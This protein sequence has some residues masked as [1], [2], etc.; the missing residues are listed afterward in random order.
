MK[1]LNVLQLNIFDILCFIYKYKQNL[2][3]AVFRII[4]TYRTK[5]NMHS[6]SLKAFKYEL[7]RFL[8][9]V[10]LNDLEILK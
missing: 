10:E 5:P 6:D 2:N 3:P 9:S 1:T 8:L 4:F 7:K